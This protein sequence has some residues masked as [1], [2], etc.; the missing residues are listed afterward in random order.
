MSTTPSAIPAAATPAHQPHTAM[1]PAE[2]AQLILLATLWGGSFFFN[3]I[4][5]RHLPPF[6]IM[7]GRALLA[8][9]A[10][11]IVLRIGGLSLPRTWRAWLPFIFMGAFNSAIPQTLILWGQTQIPSGLASILNATTPLFTVL[12]AHIVTRDEKLT[13]GKIAGVLL[14]LAGVAI[15]IGPGALQG[16][17]LNLVGEIAIL[18]AALSYAVAV[19]F[20][21]RF[22]AVSPYVTSAGQLTA[23]AII[24]LPFAL[25][26]DKPWTLPP[27]S[28]ATWGAIG[29]LAFI[30]TAFA[31]IIYFRLVASAGSTN[32]SLVTL[33]VPASA[34]LLGALFLNERLHPTDFVGMACI[35]LGLLTIDGRFIRRVMAR[36]APAL[37]SQEP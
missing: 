20:S 13:P 16:L 6:T 8:A 1:G 23:A 10:L 32:A 30:S 25:I 22:R 31:Y 37:T 12:L 33:L 7:L 19:I 14:G 24:V 36:P 2:W 21:R 34:I 26:V 3:Q 11:N 4:A 27:P 5:L 35:A 15:M 17:S 18:G 9:V 29:A 28:P